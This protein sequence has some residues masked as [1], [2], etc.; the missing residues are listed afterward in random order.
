MR[1]RITAG[2]KGRPVTPGAKP[3]FNLFSIESFCQ[4]NPP[5]DRNSQKHVSHLGQS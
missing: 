5:S 4:I 2:S 1:K 3:Y